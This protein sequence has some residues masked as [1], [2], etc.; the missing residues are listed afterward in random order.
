MGIF[1]CGSLPW[2]ALLISEVIDWVLVDKH[3]ISA[4]EK[5]CKRNE[6]KVRPVA[7][8]P[9]VPVGSAICPRPERLLGQVLFLFPCSQGRG[10][11]GTHSPGHMLGRK[12]RLL[13]S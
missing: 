4:W 12:S 5:L 8:S 13:L 10:R 6:V 3:I 1:L 11:C 7:R 2:A 9:S